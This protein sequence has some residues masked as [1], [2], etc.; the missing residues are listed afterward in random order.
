M[1]KSEPDEQLLDIFAAPCPVCVIIIIFIIILL[2]YS[3]YY[4]SLIIILL[5]LIL[6]LSS[7][8][9][10]G[11][12]R[13]KDNLSALTSVTFRVDRSRWSN[14]DVPTFSQ[15]KPKM[16]IIPYSQRILS[17]SHINECLCHD[18]SIDPSKFAIDFFAFRHLCHLCNF[19]LL[20][21]R[22]PRFLHAPLIFAII[23][24]NNNT[25]V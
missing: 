11:E 15:S 25:N 20:F 13:W 4:D 6:L 22:Y 2:L 3:N 23:Y 12:A 9:C 10:V 7:M 24:S 8:I 16:Q 5:L 19:D 14:E 18:R 1:R 17:S 21:Y